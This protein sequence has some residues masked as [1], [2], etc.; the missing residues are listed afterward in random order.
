MGTRILYDEQ[1]AGIEPFS[2]ENILVF[3]TGPLTGTKTPS[4]GRHFIVSKSPATSGITFTSSGGTWA[5]ELKKAGYDAIVVKGK[6]EKP[7]YLWIE[8]GKVE[9]RDAGMHWGKFVSETD[10]GIRD[11]THSE[12]KVLCIGPAGEKRSFTASIMNEKYRAAGRTGLGA[13]TSLQARVGN[14]IGLMSY[15]YHLF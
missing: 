5:V 7:T 11:E 6:A 9:L 14:F 4:S 15:K 10:D 3:A 8:D 13:V 2:A 12:A 1:Q